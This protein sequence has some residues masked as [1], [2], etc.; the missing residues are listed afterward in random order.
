MIFVD[1][2]VRR[3]IGK[4]SGRG[5]LPVAA[6]G[7]L[8]AA[9]ALAGCGAS[10]DRLFCASA[11]CGWTKEEWARIQTLSPLP[12]PPADTTNKYVGVDDAAKL[13]QELYFD[14]RFSGN[15]T[16]VDSIGNPVPYARAALGQ[17]INVACATCH[18]PKRAGADFTSA[19]N[20]VSIGAGW[21]D[22]NGQE[23]VN[24]AQYTLLYWNGRTDSVWAQ[25]A[26]VAESGVSV[27]G[28]RLAIFWALENDAH[29]RERYIAIFGDGEISD[30]PPPAGTYPAA[31]KPG[32]AAF[33]DLGAPDKQKITRAYVNWAKAIAAY[34]YEL[35]SRDSAFDRWVA[36]GPDSSWIS[37]AAKR[38]A[39]LFVGKASCID[40]HYGPFFT[41]NAFHDVGVPQVGDHVP[42][43]ADCFPGDAKC[44]CT[45]GDE[46]STCLPAG[47]WGG[48]LKLKADPVTD[49]NDSKLYTNF[50]RDSIWSD[51]MND[52]SRGSYY[53]APADPTLKGAW[54]TASLR[55]VALTAPYM[56]DGAYATLED[57][58]W[59]Y[60]RGG[61]ASGASQ[62]QLPIC[63]AS[64][65]V[66]DAGACMEAGAPSPGRSVQIKPLLLTDDE[67]ADLVEFLKTLTGAPL[68]PALTS[69]P[70]T[71]DGGTAAEAGATMDGPAPVDGGAPA[72]GGDGG[73]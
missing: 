32:Q 62:F 55:D 27:N 4:T 46:K 3:K 40:C 22:V 21:Y 60:N 25:A 14:T 26:A 50:R 20:T 41:D 65:S 7:A 63:T 9:L 28:N 8:T 49:P 10:G 31:G 47:A 2:V 44:D 43:V 67:V 30:P 54:R 29:Y 48:Q 42:T 58:V 45:P 24:V 68:D 53:H 39:Q 34:E 6:L 61:D 12:D 57:V 56:H 17:P 11:G 33:D 35:V 69:K 37:P 59:A 71:S 23:T 19:P 1:A 52:P 70:V 66:A 36:D 64:T 15:A 51:D 72:D 13:G 16:L 18:D 73:P 38:G 5:G